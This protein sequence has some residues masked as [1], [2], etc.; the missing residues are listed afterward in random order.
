VKHP[1]QLKRSVKKKEKLGKV[2]IKVNG[3]YVIYSDFV[4]DKFCN[5]AKLTIFFNLVSNIWQSDD[6]TA[7]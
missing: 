4:P 5:V 2:H 6:V 3:G 1:V 7:N